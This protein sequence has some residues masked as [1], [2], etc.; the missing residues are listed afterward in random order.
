VDHALEVLGAVEVLLLLE[1]VDVADERDP[2][3]VLAVGAVADG[4]PL[5]LGS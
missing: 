5:T 4:I 1:E 3:D 2:A